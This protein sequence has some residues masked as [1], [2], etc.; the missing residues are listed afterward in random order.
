M[1]SIKVS[2]FIW[3]LPELSA[4][5][6]QTHKH[7]VPPLKPLGNCAQFGI[8]AAL[9]LDFGDGGQDVVPVCPRS[10]MPLAYQMDLMLKI[11]APGILGVAAIDHEDQRHYIVRR[12]RCEGDPTQGFEVNGSYLLA[13]AQICDGDIAVRC[14]HAVGDAAAGAAAV[15]A[16]HEAGLLRCAAMNEGIDAQRPVD[17]DEPRRDSLEV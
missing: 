13:L 16:K 5:F 15:E 17:A 9:R 12:R 11:E 6:L 14:R 4:R 8:A 1:T 3:E 7:L 10:T 2:I